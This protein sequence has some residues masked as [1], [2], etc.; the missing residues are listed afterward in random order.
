MKENTLISAAEPIAA[1]TLREDFSEY[2]AH[3]QLH[4]ALHARKLVPHL[5][6]ADGSRQQLLH[7]TQADFEKFVSRQGL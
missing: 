2:V 1:P 5:N 3:L 4:M 6:S 7:Q